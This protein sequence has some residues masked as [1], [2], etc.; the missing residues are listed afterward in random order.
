[1]RDVNGEPIANA[2]CEFSVDG[3]TREMTTDGQG[4]VE[5]LIPF[6]ARRA[7]LVVIDA[8]D[9]DLDLVFD[10]DIGHLDPLDSTSGK[11]A[12][13]DNLGYFMGH[14]ADYEQI[15]ER[16]QRWAVEEFQCNNRLRVN[17]VYDGATK[18][19]LK[20]VYGC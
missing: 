9:R 16:R 3:D 17:G 6:N 19:K 11:L 15:N 4:L 12:R 2:A 1:M 14:F 10:L 8:Q 5:R 18:N 7:K 13:L 20:T